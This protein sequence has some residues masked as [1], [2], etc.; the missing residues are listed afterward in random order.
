LK[1]IYTL[2]NRI[3]DTLEHIANKYAK[4]LD[5]EGKKFTAD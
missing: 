5:D 1:E 4:Y 2:F 3:P